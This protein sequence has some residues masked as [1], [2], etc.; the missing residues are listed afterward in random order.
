M[1]QQNGLNEEQKTLNE[2]GSR[3]FLSVYRRI[4]Y[5]LIREEAGEDATQVFEEIREICMYYKI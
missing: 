4:P 5:A 2:E 1:A 3:A